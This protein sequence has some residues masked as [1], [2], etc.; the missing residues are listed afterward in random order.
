MGG[1]FTLGEN[2]VVARAACT[3]DLGVIHFCHRFET[4]RAVTGC[5]RVAGGNMAC[6]FSFRDRSIMARGADANHL[7]VVYFRRRFE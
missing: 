6:C 3:V 7:G 5:A 4:C 2:A 1:W